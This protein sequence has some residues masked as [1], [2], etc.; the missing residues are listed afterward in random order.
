MAI[1]LST[2]AEGTNIASLSAQVDPSFVLSLLPETWRNALL[3]VLA[4]VGAMRFAGKLG[5]TALH[6][7]FAATK[8]Q[9]D[10]DFLTRIENSAALRTFLFWIDLLLSWKPYRGP[11]APAQPN[12]PEPAGPNTPPAPTLPGAALMFMLALVGISIGCSHLQPG[13]DPLIVRTEQ[14]EKIAAATFDEILRLDDGN[15]AF[16]RTNAPQF[17]AFAERLRAADDFHGTN[18]PNA[19]TVILRLN[20]LKTLYRLDHSNSN[21]LVTAVAGI[22]AAA[23]EAKTLKPKK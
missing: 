12:R 9:A 22:E 2:H 16:Y 4:F 15:R 10:D 21:L 19:V 8:T 14:T 7:V 5:C 17:H 1:C 3:A 6:K 18:Y 11:S 13:A 20:E 23:A